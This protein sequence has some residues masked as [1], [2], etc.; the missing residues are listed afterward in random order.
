MRIFTFDSTLHDG[1]HCDRVSSGPD[2]KLLSGA[3]NKLRIL[4][5]LDDFGVDYVDG[6]WASD[7]RD[8]EFFARARAIVLKRSR[9]VASGSATNLPDLLAAATPVVCFNAES[10]D[11]HVF[12]TLGITADE[13]LSTI[14]SSV[15]TLKAAGREVIYNA[16]H[17]FDAWEANP[18][19]AL[20][21]IEAAHRAGA[22]VICL[23][24]SNGGA[25]PTRVGE[26]CREVRS[27]IDGIL[28]I[29]AHNDGDLAVANTLAAVE[30]GF[31]HVQGCINGYGERCGCANLCSIIPNLELKAGHTTVGRDRLEKLNGLAHFI[32]ESA[33]LSLPQEQPYV[34]QGAFTIG[35]DHTRPEYVGGSPPTLLPEICRRNSA[36]SCSMPSKKKSTRVTI[37]P[38]RM[39]HSNCYSARP[40]PLTRSSSP[41]STTKWTPA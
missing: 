17:F 9:L 5:R 16:E 41:L 8:R 28:G 40:S 37:W 18:T 25:L 36:A 22:D 21:T 2:N 24:D 32:A 27:S 34:G 1:T 3:D 14:F 7:P 20:S 31:T 39:E 23:C 11:L 6:G 4:R 19:F 10:W 26:V 35:A 33:N 30:Q 15:H 29:H 38:A 13:H 12:K